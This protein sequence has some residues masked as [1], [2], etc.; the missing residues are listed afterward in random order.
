MVVVVVVASTE[1]AV[2]PVRDLVVS[3]AV[4]TAMARQQH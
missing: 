3:V 4:V 2:M 1:V